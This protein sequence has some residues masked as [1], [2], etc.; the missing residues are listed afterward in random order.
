MKRLIDVDDWTCAD[1]RKL[2]STAKLLRHHLWQN[3]NNAGVIA[4]DFDAF[5]FHIGQ[6]VNKQ[7][8]TELGSW[9]Q[10]LPGDYLFIP[11]FI[12]C[13]YGKLKPGC[14]PHDSVISILA[15]HGI[16]HDI[17]TPKRKQY[18]KG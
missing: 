15:I 5:S 9:V 11:S 18:P 7:H 3:C 17:T 16:N 10:H 8:L 6:T 12:R 2:S 13:Q 14:R 1:Y 4:I